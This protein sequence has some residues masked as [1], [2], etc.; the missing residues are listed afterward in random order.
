MSTVLSHGTNDCL[1]R[2]QNWLKEG[3]NKTKGITEKKKKGRQELRTLRIRKLHI[4]CLFYTSD[5]GMMPGGSNTFKPSSFLMIQME[6]N[7][8]DSK[9]MGNEIHC[10]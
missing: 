10:R 1:I 8:P 9:A 4:L 6:N 7:S 5:M 2:I 3:A